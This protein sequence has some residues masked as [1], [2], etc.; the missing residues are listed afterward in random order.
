VIYGD[1]PIEINSGLSHVRYQFSPPELLLH[2]IIMFIDCSSETTM[3]AD[4]EN[5]ETS[6]FTTDMT[7]NS[8]ECTTQTVRTLYLII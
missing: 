4:F 1:L 2:C 5:G 7:D 3:T 6:I 8:F